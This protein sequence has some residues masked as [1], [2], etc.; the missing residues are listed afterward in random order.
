VAKTYSF[1]VTATSTAS[2]A[3][4]FALAVDATTWP[5]WTPIGRAARGPLSPTGTE[6][7]GTIR[8]FS[9]GMVTSHERITEINDGT[10]ITYCLVKGLPIG[11]HTA[12]LTVTPNGD[13]C[14]ITWTESFTEKIPL[15]GAFFK[16][17]LAAFIAKCANGLAAAP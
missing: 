5:S 11:D 8:K 15:T 7:V 1:T 4:R 16:A 13:G 3:S 2:A 10:S 17:F 12:T 6:Q 9:T 14:T